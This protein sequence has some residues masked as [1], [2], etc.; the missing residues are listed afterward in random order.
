[1]QLFL[2]ELAQTHSR[3]NPSRIIVISSLA[4]ILPSIQRA[5]YTA[6]KHALQG[7]MTALRGETDVKVTICCPDYVDT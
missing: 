6:A 4:G 3:T 2:P 1:M 5:P 7:F